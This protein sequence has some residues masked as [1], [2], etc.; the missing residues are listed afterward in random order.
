MHA[1][2]GLEMLLVAVVDQRIQ[3]VDGFDPDIAAASA[4]TTIRPAELDEF[5]TAERDGACAAVA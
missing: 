4:I 1:G 2:L 3:P 5:L